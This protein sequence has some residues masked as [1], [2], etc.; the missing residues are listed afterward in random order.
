[1]KCSH[2][3]WFLHSW[4]LIQPCDA[5]CSTWFVHAC[6]PVVY[7]VFHCS[8]V[9]AELLLSKGVAVLTDIQ[10]DGQRTVC[11]AALKGDASYAK[12]HESPNIVSYTGNMLQQMSSVVVM[13]D[14]QSQM[15][16]HLIAQ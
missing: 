5:S 10:Y 4:F 7:F 9:L 3:Y 12:H 13:P 6:L 15:A 14:E 16:L 11:D 2:D 1:V 8:K